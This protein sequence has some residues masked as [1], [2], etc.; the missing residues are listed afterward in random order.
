MKVW[1]AALI[2]NPLPRQGSYG[3]SGR[4][5]GFSNMPQV[6]AFFDGDFVGAGSPKAG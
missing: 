3:I 6:A 1:P 5:G 4:F 2:A